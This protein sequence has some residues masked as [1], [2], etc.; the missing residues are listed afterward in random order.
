MDNNLPKK[1]L[2]SVLRWLAW[3]TLKRY[4]P[5][6]VGI[7][8]SVGKTS[9][10][11]AIYLVL[12]SQFKVRRSQGNY[13]NEIGV[14]L[15]VLGETSAGRSVLGWL[16][17]FIKSFLRVVYCQ[18]PEILIIEMGIDRPGD[19]DYLLKFI[20]VKV[21]VITKISEIPTHLEF[22]TGVEELAKEKT[23]LVRGLSQDNYAVTNFDDALIKK[24]TTD[25][26]AKTVSFGFNK[27]ADVRASNIVL[28]SPEIRGENGIGG[29]SFK[30]NYQNSI[31]PVR[32]P[33]IL[34][35]HQILATLAAAAC[36]IIFDVNL[37]N[38]SEVLREMKS[39]KGRM[40]LIPG[41][42]NTNI[43]DDTYNASPDSTLAA[44]QVLKEL[45]PE[46]RK[47]VILG[48]MKELGEQSEA[49]HRKVGSLV[50]QVA[51]ILVVI[52][53]AAL[54]I[55]DQ[56]QKNGLSEKF[57]GHFTEAEAAA[58]FLQAKVL[59]ENDLLLIKGSQSMRMEKA[60]KK[61][62]AEPLKAKELL[63][64]QEECWLKK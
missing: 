38:V 47:V 31:L 60:V 21:G 54:F 17:L 57:I 32:L 4:Q 51:D 35:Q 10:K 8:G 33:Y 40:S 14:P 15:T 62:M 52:G 5:Q 58:E 11:E 42:K 41:I 48:D 18:Y 6:V 53:D 1:I 55:A 59:Q 27:G 20:K 19:M 22:F 3:L 13:N 61:L 26:K 43:I 29:I 49:G 39:P 7:T 44:L 30:L 28:D 9:T 56:A 46:G 36:G 64:R 37:V 25:L 23:K 16:S 2:Q 24:F 34:A 45:K 50:A 12:G 63:A